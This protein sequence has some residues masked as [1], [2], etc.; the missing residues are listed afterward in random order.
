M[1]SFPASSLSN[2]ISPL[3]FWTGRPLWLTIISNKRSIDIQWKS[4]A[5]FGRY[6]RHFPV[7]RST[8]INSIQSSLT[9]LIEPY[10]TGR[11]KKTTNILTTINS[12]R[13]KE[14]R[15]VA[16]QVIQCIYDELKSLRKSNSLV[17]GKNSFRKKKLVNQGRAESLLHLHSFVLVKKR[18]RCT[19]VRSRLSET[20][21]K[22]EAKKKR[23]WI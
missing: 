1:V 6:Q 22:I 18:A 2:R 7:F 11:T 23:E 10:D 15:E 9:L 14:R 21:R 16:R 13:T 3:T 4:P 8:K 19:L 20:S 17:F 5:K 12:R